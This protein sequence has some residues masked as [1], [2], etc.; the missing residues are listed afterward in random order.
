MICDSYIMQKAHLQY[1][2]KLYFDSFVTEHLVE[3]KLYASA[4]VRK[5][6]SAFVSIKSK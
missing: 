3:Q 4:Q 5:E 6:W 1:F 2:S